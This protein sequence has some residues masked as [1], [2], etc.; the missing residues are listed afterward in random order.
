LS[1]VSRGSSVYYDKQGTTFFWFDIASQVYASGTAFAAPL[2]QAGL[3]QLM[4]ENVVAAMLW[5]LAPTPNTTPYLLAPALAGV[6]QA[7]ASPRMTVP[8][9]ARDYTVHVWDV[10]GPG[11]FENVVN[12]NVPAP[13]VA[14]FLDALRCVGGFT[15][16]AVDAVTGDYPYNAA[17]PK[18]GSGGKP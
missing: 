10:A 8:P 14:D 2:K 5:G 9:Y 18:C 3:L 11:V 16:A 7:L 6:W 13:M 1:A 15:A 4:D 17:S 12:T